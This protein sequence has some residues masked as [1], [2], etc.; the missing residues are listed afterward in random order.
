MGGFLPAGKGILHTEAQVHTDSTAI[1]W[2][3]CG[4][5]GQRWHSIWKRASAQSPGRRVPG[6]TQAFEAFIEPPVARTSPG[7]AAR[8]C[9]SWSAPSSER[10][11]LPARRAESSIELMGVHLAEPPL[12]LEPVSECWW[13]ESNLPQQSFAEQ[14]CVLHTCRR[15]SQEPLALFAVGFRTQERPRREKQREAGLG[16]QGDRGHVGLRTKCI[17]FALHPC[18]KQNHKMIP[19]HERE[20]QPRAL[21]AGG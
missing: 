11:Q 20:G 2:Q 4:R 5:S 17:S 6:A 3:R 15:G 19:T 1:G 18:A 13:V 14:S 8:L 12:G 9:G 21:Q 7:R 16:A 10:L